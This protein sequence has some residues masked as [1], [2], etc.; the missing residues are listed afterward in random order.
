MNAVY[1]E[2]QITLP[3]GARLVLYS[4]GVHEAESPDGQQFGYS[5]IERHFTNPN[6]SAD[7]LLSEISNFAGGLSLGDDATVVTIDVRTANA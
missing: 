5:S 1:V 7:S 4:D 3:P 6:A 2:E